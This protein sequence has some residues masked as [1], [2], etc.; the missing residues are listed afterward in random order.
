MS[1]FSIQEPKDIEFIS[2]NSSTHPYQIPNNIDISGYYEVS[3]EPINDL[4]YPALTYNNAEKDVS[5]SFSWNNRDISPLIEGSINGIAYSPELGLFVMVTQQG[6]NWRFASSSDGI[7]WTNRNTSFS[8]ILTNVNKF[9]ISNCANAAPAPST[10]LVCSDTSGLEIGTIIGAGSNSPAPTPTTFPFVTQ[11]LDA[12]N[13]LT[14][15][16]FEIVGVTA[17]QGTTLCTCTD[18]SG[19]FPGMGV[20]RTGGTLGTQSARFISSVPSSTKFVLQNTRGYVN[21][22]CFADRTYQGVVWC[23]DLSGVGMFVATASSVPQPGRMIFTSTDGINWIQ[24]T[25]PSVITNGCGALCYSPEL[26]RVIA[27]FEGGTNRGFIYSD[28]G[29]N[30]N[31]TITSPYVPYYSIAWSPQLR[32]FAAPLLGSASSTEGILISPDGINWTPRTS[33]FISGSYSSIVWSEQLGIFV[34]VIG[35]PPQVVIS[36]NGVNWT[37]VSSPGITTSFRPTA[38]AWSPQLRCFILAGN[39]DIWF[40][41][42][43][44]NWSRFTMTNA[45]NSNGFKAI[46]WSEEKGIFIVGGGTSSSVTTTDLVF[47]STLRATPPTSYNIFDSSFSNISELGQWTFPIFGRGIPVTKTTSFTVAPAENWIICNGAGI[48]V[49]LPDA[50]KNLGE[51]ITIKTIA[52]S[53]VTSSPAIVQLDGTE[54]TSLLAATAGKWKTLVSNGSK[55]VVLQAN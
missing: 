50:S 36:S 9:D 33:L 41:Y 38:L 49:T 44:R 35:T 11:I 39:K 12:S 28:D 45:G 42:N 17:N 23:K 37:T 4:F 48:T 26:K 1:S 7:N 55:W 19:L 8:V 15:I 22:T 34:S 13:F 40:S 51:E 14:S 54:S 47:T 18:T 20:S 30:W 16:R 31:A 24:R 43:G 21:A 46:V 32:L 10:Q 52:A 29:I 2:N 53:A 27:A 6:I 3:G 25:T 5:S